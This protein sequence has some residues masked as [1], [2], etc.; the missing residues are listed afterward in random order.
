M[1]CYDFCHSGFVDEFGYWSGALEVQ[2]RY[3]REMRDK[4]IT[5][6]DACTVN[7]GIRLSRV[8]GKL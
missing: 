6:V 8:S 3:T 2:H 5:S 1:H 4:I 7:N